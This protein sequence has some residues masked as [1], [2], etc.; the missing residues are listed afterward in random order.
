MSPKNEAELLAV[1]ALVG[2]LGFIMAGS[3][4][5][6]LLAGVYLDR[7]LGSG[8]VLTIVLLLC[9]IGGGFVAVYRLVMRAVGGE[10]EQ[11]GGRNQT[12]RGQ[13]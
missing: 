9:G 13:R 6:G 12:D 4:L 5:G 3:I 10:T 11:E 2:Q 7:W 1:L 8:P